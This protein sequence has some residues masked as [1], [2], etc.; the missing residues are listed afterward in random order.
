MRP[1]LEIALAPE[2]MDEGNPEERACFGLLT[3]RANEADLTGGMNFFISAYRPGPLVSGYH[4]AEWLAWNWWRLCYEPRAAMPDWWRAHKMTAIGEGYAWPNI[5]I[6]SDGVRTTILS[7]PSVRP[8]VKPFRCVGSIP[9]VLPSI[10][11]QAA[12]DRF[13]SIVQARLREQGVDE[14][15]LDRIWRDVMA[16]RKAPELARRR[17]LEAL[18]GRDADAI[19]DQLVDRLIADTAEVG[20]PA[21]EELAGHGGQGGTPPSA[22]DIWQ[23]ADADGYDALPGDAV[24]LAGSA[25]TMSL[26][27]PAWRLGAEAAQALRAQERLGADPIADDRLAALAGVDCEA[28]RGNKTGP[29]LSFAL[30]GTASDG[31]VVLRSKWR[32]GRRFEL[33]RLLADRIV[34]P[35]DGR[36]HV[37]TR[38]YTY[39][40]QMQRSFAAELL[41]PL[42]ALDAM[43]DG[44]TSAEAQSDAAEY[45]QVSDRTVLSLLVNH[46]RVGR[47]ELEE[48]PGAAV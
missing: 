34:A 2:R 32:T 17:R 1:P 39:R 5:T 19:D 8:D 26:E 30:D 20:V 41:S 38:A 15:G 24:R 43:L 35:A 45:F 23:S 36:L 18:L 16:E 22:A 28:L 47:Y 42:E 13:I 7:E 31:R 25:S 40:Q 4:A 9:C 3:I 14:T 21:V 11:F 27:M 46:R 44:D 10:H 12:V 37:A 48:D 6:F 33:A 29:S